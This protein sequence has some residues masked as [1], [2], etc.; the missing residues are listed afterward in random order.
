MSSTRR[1]WKYG[2]RP[3]DI[4]YETFELDSMK[5]LL[6][7]SL[8]NIAWNKSKIPSQE[9]KKKFP[10]ATLRAHSASALKTCSMC[11]KFQI[12]WNHTL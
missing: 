4:I 9:L 5:S 2:P 6:I 7:E 12:L 8:G 11:D 3:W 10:D 1:K